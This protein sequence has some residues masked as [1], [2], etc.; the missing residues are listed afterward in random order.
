M[1]AF[2]KGRVAFIS[3]TQIVIETAGGIGYEI[4]ISLYTFEKI[5]DKE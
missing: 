2:I 4:Q 5:K 3:P 1:I